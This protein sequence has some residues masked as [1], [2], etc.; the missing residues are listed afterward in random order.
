MRFL[1]GSLSV[2]N[3][4]L[5]WKC[6]YGR[7]KP[8]AQI[9]HKSHPSF[10]FCPLNH[11]S[12]RVPG[13]CVLSSRVNM[14]FSFSCKSNMRTWS[15]VV[16]FIALLKLCELKTDKIV[17]IP[18][19]MSPIWLSGVHECTW[20]WLTPCTDIIIKWNSSNEWRPNWGCSSSWLCQP[21]VRVSCSRPLHYPVATLQPYHFNARLS[22][23]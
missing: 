7:M 13:F 10:L 15:S 20:V 19:S 3:Y 16:Y 8:S 12:V 18:F 1:Q 22:T 23:C 5:K 11:R 9:K 4:S 21:K 14:I 17:W 2:T 6:S